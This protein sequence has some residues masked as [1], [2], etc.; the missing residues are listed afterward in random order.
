MGTRDAGVAA[1]AVAAADE[2]DEEDDAGEA[3][4]GAK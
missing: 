1:D 4:G 2:G 3:E